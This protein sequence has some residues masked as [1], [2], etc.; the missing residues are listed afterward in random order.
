MAR[1]YCS[2]LAF[3]LVLGSCASF[4]LVSPLSPRSFNQLNDKASFEQ[5]HTL[6]ARRETI[7]MPTNTPMVPYKPP[8]SD[9]AQFISLDSRMY[10]DRIMFIGKYIDEAAANE[11]ISILLYLRKEDPTG[12]ITLYFNVP[13]AQLR[14]A[15]AVYDLICQTR[16]NCE[17]STVNIGLCTGMGALL[18]GAGTKGRRCAMPNSRFLLQRTGMESPYQGQA[19]DIGLE[20]SNMKLMN[21]RC[22]RELSK[23]TGQAS[24]KVVEDM[25]RDFYLSSDEA[26]RY[27][28]IDKVLLPALRKRAT[29][30]KDT[31]L[32]AFEG[33]DVQRYQNEKS[34]GFGGGW[35][36]AGARGGQG[37]NDD[38]DY[39]PPAVKQ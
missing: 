6:W 1:I 36:D 39:E 25:K 17:I 10:R 34:S 35:K 31:D 27:G 32:G 11:I 2:T 13:G 12:E 37:D 33:E 14:P 8:G 15:L 23:L 30:G 21:D 38:D 18:C 5:K 7:K 9:Y 3:L 28:L 19:S 16:E 20:V 26:V 22:E 24:E 29:T 4:S